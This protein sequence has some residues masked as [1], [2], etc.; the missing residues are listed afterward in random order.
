MD[1]Y[2]QEKAEK[3]MSG[4]QKYQPD[5]FV[6]YV[7]CAFGIR[8]TGRDRSGKMG[9]LVYNLRQR[10]PTRLASFLARTP[11]SLTTYVTSSITYCN[12]ESSSESHRN[13]HATQDPPSHTHGVSERDEPP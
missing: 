1:T 9:F 5:S 8:Y 3:G 11:T 12:Y 4:F 2:M 6:V 10:M 7:Q 13:D